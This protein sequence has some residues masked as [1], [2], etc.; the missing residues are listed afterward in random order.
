[1][2]LFNWIMKGIGFESEE[3]EVA[4][5]SFNDRPL[6]KKEMK[7]LKKE[8]KKNKKNK[9]RGY[10][11]SFNVM[12]DSFM[13]PNINVNPN[14]FAMNRDQFNT[15]R[16]QEFDSMGETGYT[17]TFN[18]YGSYNQKNFV[19]FTPRCYDDIKKLIEY[20]KQTEPSI[21]NLDNISD[22]EAQRILDFVSG[23][24]CALNGSI[25]RIKGNIFLVA[26]E[27]FN[28]KISKD[29]LQG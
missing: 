2:G 7:A 23:G 8:Q 3:E 15:V 10:D 24:V 28:I 5:D 6:T 27:G 4:E 20:L 26:P 11:D 21:L 18:P 19:F 16:P 12:T 9:S 22:D 1:M 25:Q 14:S 29:Q 13:Q 17:Q